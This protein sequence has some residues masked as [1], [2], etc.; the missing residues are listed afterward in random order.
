M[1]VVSV[2]SNTNLSLVVLL[3]SGVFTWWYIQLSVNVHNKEQSIWYYWAH[4]GATPYRYTF[5]LT[6]L[7]SILVWSRVVFIFGKKQ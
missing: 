2:V 6:L 4:L 1:S 7:L 3:I 5:L